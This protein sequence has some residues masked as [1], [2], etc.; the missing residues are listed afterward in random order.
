[1]VFRLYN[2]LSDVLQSSQFQLLLVLLTRLRPLIDRELARRGN[3]QLLLSS[4][5]S[6]F[7]AHSIGVDR[8]VIDRSWEILRPHRV[9]FGQDID[10]QKLADDIFRILGPQYDL[11]MPSM[12]SH[13]L[14]HNS[15]PMQPQK[16]FI[17]L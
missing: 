13:T 17:R 7:L 12:T 14:C 5:V 6:E 2:Q 16:H 9:S 8:S 4:T 11:G 1:M 15:S 3:H 10:Y